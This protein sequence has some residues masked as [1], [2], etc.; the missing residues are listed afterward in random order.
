MQICSFVEITSILVISS[1]VRSFLML[2][3]IRWYYN[4]DPILNNIFTRLLL[5]KLWHLRVI[6]WSAITFD[7]NQAWIPFDLLYFY[8]YYSC[9]IVQS[10]RNFLLTV[11]SL[12]CTLSS[13]YLSLFSAF[14]WFYNDSHTHKHFWLPSVWIVN[15]LPLTTSLG[16]WGLIYSHNRYFVDFLYNIFD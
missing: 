13:I 11:S 7:S 2:A 15:L 12:I 9:K 5:K 6:L 3:S 1:H 14:S 4:I 16:R 10:Y 8:Y